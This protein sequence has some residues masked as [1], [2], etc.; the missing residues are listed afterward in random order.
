MKSLFG[1]FQLSYDVEILISKDLHLRLKILW[2]GVTY[3]D[4]VL[5]QQLHLPKIFGNHN[6]FFSTIR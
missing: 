1:L 2:S 3:D 4:L 5:K 6:T